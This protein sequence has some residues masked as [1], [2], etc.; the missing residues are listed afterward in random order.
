[1]NQKQCEIFYS[2][3]RP[4]IVL[5][6]THEKHLKV[7]QLNNVWKNATFV[8]CLIR[9]VTKHREIFGNAD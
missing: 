3:L 4:T 8:E 7:S 2:P 6:S 1:M 5:A 9:F